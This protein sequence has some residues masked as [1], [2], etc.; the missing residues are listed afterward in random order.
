MFD[1]WHNAIDNYYFVE[2]N[3]AGSWAGLPAGVTI[4]NW[5]LSNLQNSLTWFSGLNAQQPVPYRQII[6]G[7][8]DSGDGAAAAAQELEQAR[9]IPGVAGLMY[10]TWN[11]DYSQL[12][13]FAVAAKSNWAGYL[14]SV[15]RNVTAQ[16]RV[17]ASGITLSRATGRY[18][19][20]VTLTNSGETLASAAYVLDSLP[21]GVAVYQPDGYTSAALP[22]GS[23]FQSTGAAGAGASVTLTIQFT[24]IGTPAI[25]YTARVLG[26][27]PK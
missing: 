7:Y 27:G 10:T 16:F 6:A 2:G 12:Q 26:P 8:Y 11:P 22:A 17:N 1:P 13:A 20:T 4:L 15:V 25:T 9:G 23:P 19:Q 18:S 14:A 24:R 21:A 5:N 3:I